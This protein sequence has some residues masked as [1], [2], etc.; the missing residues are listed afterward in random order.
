MEF[1]EFLLSDSEVNNQT[2]YNTAH[3]IA[4]LKESGQINYT[5][6][7]QAHE[8]IINM[9]LHTLKE[10]YKLTKKQVSSLMNIVSDIS[11]SIVQDVCL[12]SP[13]QLYFIILDDKKETLIHQEKL[14]YNKCL[15]PNT[16]EII[17][18]IYNEIK[19]GQWDNFINTSIKE[20]G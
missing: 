2:N 19:V 3:I 1:I 4:R 14:P 20:L 8:K 13:E 11:P 10:Q 9:A 15:K 18:K 17:K 12:E 6:Q 5:D 16:K 7:G